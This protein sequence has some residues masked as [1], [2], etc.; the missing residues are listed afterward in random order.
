MPLKRE[1]ELT[2]IALRDE[3]AETR[4]TLADWK[5]KHDGVCD[6]LSAVCMGFAQRRVR[7]GHVEIQNDIDS[8][9]E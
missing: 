6:Q 1:L 9:T 5:H 8:L 3:L 7:H 2:I 4:E